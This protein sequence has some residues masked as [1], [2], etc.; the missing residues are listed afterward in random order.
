MFFW[1][2]TQHTVVILSFL[3]F[4][5]GTNSLCWTSVWNYHSTLPEEHRSPT[6]LFEDYVEKCTGHSESGH[7]PQTVPVDSCHHSLS[8]PN[9]QM[10]LTAQH[11]IQ[12]QATS[13][14]IWLYNLLPHVSSWGHFLLRRQMKTNVLHTNGPQHN[15]HH[16]I[17]NRVMYSHSRVCNCLQSNTFWILPYNI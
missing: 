13:T 12:S 15:D 3:T 16:G 6:E 4:E 14:F 17:S 5:D 8:Q 7:G 10:G 9:T 2:F 1:N 11:I